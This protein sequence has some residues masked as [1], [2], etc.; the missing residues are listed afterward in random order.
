VPL[1]PA[2]TMSA[3]RITIERNPDGLPKS[4]DQRQYERREAENQ[5]LAAER[6]KPAPEPA[7]E[8][9]PMTFE[10]RREMRLAQALGQEIAAEEVARAKAAVP[11]LNPFR[12]RAEALRN[13]PGMQKRFDHYCSLA[14]ARDR[15][16]EQAKLLAEHNEA[17]AND[18]WI[19]TSREYSAALLVT[20]PE[21]FKAEAATIK[22]IADSG[23]AP[24][25]AWQKIKDLE[26]RVW[27]HLDRE[28]EAKL[29]NR[30]VTDSEYNAAAELAE[31]ARE[32]SAT[33][34]E[35]IPV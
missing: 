1:T 5:R 21:A 22:A 10:Q 4:F 30:L 8:L 6:L 32:L 34:C 12:A 29:Q 11:V 18:P 33:N 20:V 17:L 19:K 25:V 3:R 7:P 28:A 35:P 24:Q 2:K 15:E 26:T 16:L 14:D 31:A 9:P 27:A 23:D 13:K